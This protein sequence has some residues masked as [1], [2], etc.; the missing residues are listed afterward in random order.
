MLDYTEEKIWLCTSWNNTFTASF[1][2]ASWRAQ[3]YETRCH[4]GWSRSRLCAGGGRGRPSGPGRSESAETFPAAVSGS[5]VW[6][7]HLDWPHGAFRG[8]SRDKVRDCC[9]AVLWEGQSIP[10]WSKVRAAGILVHA[11]VV[12][13][14]SGRAWVSHL[15]WLGETRF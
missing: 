3:C 10:A 6:C 2:C 5:S 14:L 9:P 8:T 7:S 4:H 11:A 1:V 15:V 12:G 13:N